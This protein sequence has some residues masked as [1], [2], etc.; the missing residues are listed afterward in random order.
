MYGSRTVQ[1]RALVIAARA[2][3]STTATER[4]LRLAEA[5][6][7]SLGRKRPGR[8]TGRQLFLRDMKFTLDRMRLFGKHAP[9]G[10][11]K[12]LIFSHGAKRRALPDDLRRNLEERAAMKA[13]ENKNVLVER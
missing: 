10:F 12:K 9:R 2:L 11:A 6:L 7:A 4:K 1:D 13:L 3:F 5:R 8:F